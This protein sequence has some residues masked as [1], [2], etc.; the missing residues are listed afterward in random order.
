MIEKG[1]FPAVCFLPLKILW[2][3]WE[4]TDVGL[5]KNLIV[6]LGDHFSPVRVL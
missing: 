1:I 5:G 3:S 2:K 6:V 4:S